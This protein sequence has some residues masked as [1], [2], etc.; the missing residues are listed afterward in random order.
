MCLYIFTN[1]GMMKKIQ[2]IILLFYWSCKPSSESIHN[3]ENLENKEITTERIDANPVYAENLQH[4]PPPFLSTQEILKL[5]ISSSLKEAL[6]LYDRFIK[7]SD[8]NLKNE[9]L[10][11]V[12]KLKTK[13]KND[14]SI[15]TNDS[16]N[17]ASA[18]EQSFTM[19]IFSQAFALTGDNSYS[20]KIKKLVKAFGDSVSNGGF[21]NSMNDLPF[22]TNNSKN[23]KKILIHHNYALL[24]LYYT[25]KVI[26]DENAIVYF[27]QGAQALKVSLK[28]F[29][30][31]FTSLYDWEFTEDGQ[32]A[33][34]SAMGENPD[35]HHELLIKQLVELYLETKEPIFKQYAHLFLKQDMGAFASND[36]KFSEIKASHSVDSKLLSVKH[37]DDELWSWGKYWS[38]NQFPTDL[39]IEFDTEKYGIEALTF[40]SIKK[41]TAPKEFKIFVEKE[42]KW[43]FV[44]NSSDIKKIHQNY[45][46]TGNYESFIDTYFLPKNIEGRAIKIEF[47]SSYSNNLITLREINIMYNRE[48]ELEKLITKSK[49][50]MGLLLLN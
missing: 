29:D 25:N 6:T 38:T 39:T 12:N 30:G 22:Y 21:Q 46:L 16:K 28:D 10:N 50:G 36:S 13:D 20:D 24:A 4:F 15:V 32:Y 45:Y 43:V 27:D 3:N 8:K 7:T 33:Y 5:D 31:G 34:A 49:M 1:F 23:A 11:K 41:D 40:V 44:I 14:F 35:F 37:L 9:F 26:P 19:V 42:G 2:L 48:L 17:S 47:L 18:V